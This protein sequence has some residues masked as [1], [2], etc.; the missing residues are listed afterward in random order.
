MLLLQSLRPAVH[1]V[2]LHLCVE[3]A[4]YAAVSHAGHGCG[5]VRTN[6]SMQGISSSHLDPLRLC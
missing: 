3:H 6:K 4:L 5:S 2:C 1:H